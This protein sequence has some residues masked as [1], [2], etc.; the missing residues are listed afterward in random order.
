M[1]ELDPR[2]SAFRSDLADARLKGRVAA[3]RFVAGT[4]RRVVAP[5]APLRCA[6]TA[7]APLD[8]ELLRGEIFT[9]FETTPDGLAWGQLETDGY[10][11]HVPVSALSATLTPT[12]THRVSAL[13]AFVFREPDMRTPPLFA[14]SFGAQVAVD[15]A[16]ET[17]GIHYSRLADGEGWMGAVTLAPVGARSAEDYVTVA[18]RFL[19]VPYLWGGRTSLGLDCSALV[20]HALAAMGKSAPR[21]SD[22]QEKLLGQPLVG[23]VAQAKRGDLLF[24]PGHVA[25]CRDAESIVHASGTFMAVVVEPLSEALPRMGPPRSVSRPL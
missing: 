7:D 19:N 20:Q 23:G 15:G 17:R 2:T 12:P 16:A 8:S 25:I 24:W 13:R 4:P 21:D 3:D 1:T 10:V 14:L 22:L 5:S 18:E 6:R 9:V 11:G